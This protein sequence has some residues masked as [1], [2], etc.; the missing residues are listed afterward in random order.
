MEPYRCVVFGQN[1]TRPAYQTIHAE[2]DDQAKGIAMNLLRDDPVIE[3]MELFRG[4]Y[5]VFRLTRNQAHLEAL[6]DEGKFAS[7]RIG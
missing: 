2:T 4:A 6:G 5:F 1:G 3:K 7:N